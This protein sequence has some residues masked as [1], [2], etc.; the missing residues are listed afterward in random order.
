MERLTFKVAEY[1]A[2]L[3]L[4]LFLISRHKLDI[5]D[6]DIIGPKRHIFLW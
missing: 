2:P 3:D 6:I 5:L 4:I 1:D